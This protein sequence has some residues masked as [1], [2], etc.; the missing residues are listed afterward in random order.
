MNI[1]GKVFQVLAEARGEGKNGPWS[2]LENFPGDRSLPD[3]PD[4]AGSGQEDDL[5]F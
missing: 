1:S 3:L 5:P 2:R 4:S